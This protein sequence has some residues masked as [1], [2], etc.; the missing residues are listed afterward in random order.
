MSKKP[1]EKEL[2]TYERLRQELLADQGKFAVICG[3]RLIG[4][5]ND[6]E[7]ALRSGYKECGGGPFLVKRIEHDETVHYFTRDVISPCPR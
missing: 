2:E 5:Y 4:T 1:L 7:D 3:D 6:Y